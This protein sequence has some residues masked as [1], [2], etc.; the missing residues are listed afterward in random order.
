MGN[1]YEFKNAPESILDEVGGKGASLVKLTRL[2]L[3][4][5]EGYVVGTGATEDEIRG[6]VEGLSDS[7]TYAVRSSA[8]NER[9]LNQLVRMC[10][11]SRPGPFLHTPFMAVF[12]P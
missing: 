2:G 7:Y 8:I 6:L 9:L 11:S 5:P 10:T 1:I 4:V 3:P 12:S